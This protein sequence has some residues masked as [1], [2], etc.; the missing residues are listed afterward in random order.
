MGEAIRSR[1]PD[2]LAVKPR[3][4]LAIWLTSRILRQKFHVLTSLPGFAL[5]CDY[6]CTFTRVHSRS[7]SLVQHI[8]FCLDKCQN[9]SEN[10][11]CLTAISSPAQHSSSLQTWVIWA[12]N[13]AILCIIPYHIGE[14]F[15]K[16]VYR[17]CGTI[18]ECM[19]KFKHVWFRRFRCMLQD[20]F[21]ITDAT[22]VS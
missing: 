11:R 10:V 8:N 14:G 15:W 4:C 16:G 9:C 7:D 20:N 12:K 1:L 2:S 18:D 5:C 17:L 3:Y 13:L 21:W 6:T 19:Q 22:I